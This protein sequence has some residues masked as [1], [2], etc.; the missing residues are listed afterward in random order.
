MAQHHANG[1]AGSPGW[2]DGDFPDAP[3]KPDPDSRSAATPDPAGPDGRA[4]PDLR[5]EGDRGACVQ[6][7]GNALQQN[8]L[9]QKTAQQKSLRQTT[10]QQTTPQQR[11]AQQKSLRQT[12]PQQTT[13]QQTTQPRKALSS[14]FGR[15]DWFA[16]PENFGRRPAAGTGRDRARSLGRSV[17]E[18][19]QSL[20]GWRGHGGWP[21]P[22]GHRQHEVG[23]PAV[24]RPADPGTQPRRWQLF[25]AAASLAL[26]SAAVGGI[27][28]GFVAAGNAGSQADPGYSVSL[29]PPAPPSRPAGSVAGVAARDLPGVVMIK[30]NGGQG[31]G[32]GFVIQGGYI[33]TDNHVVTLDGLA[34]NASIRVY[35]SDG[36]SAAAQ[37]VGRDPYSDIAV[38]KATGVTGLPALSLG[39][40]GTVAVGDPV[41]AIGSPLGLVDTV[42][43]GIVSAV[44]RP[45]QPASA[46]GAAPQDFFDAIQTDA[47]IN[48][49][50]SGGPLV[51]ARGQVIGVDAAIDTLGSD[52][53]TGTQGG[54]IGLGFAIPVNQARRII[55]EL[56]RTGHATHSVLGADLNENFAGAGAQVATSGRGVV[57]GGPAARAGLHPGDVITKLGSQPIMSADSLL[58]AI[59]SLPPGSTVGIT[60]SRHGQRMVARITLGSAGS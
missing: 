60:F 39:N 11:T 13:P 9:Q 22:P 3:A 49:G 42:T 54:S 32:S 29:G 16:E 18:T 25:G 4:R 1:S 37:V 26:V 12:T 41:L 33:V 28:G 56:I 48:P 36:R 58:D 7:Q 45:V 23:D 52:P 17:G 10:P 59:R 27:A 57:P 43:S 53:I 34:G 21:P 31:T 8:V 20:P 2:P 55:V 38:I 5:L 15:F 44:N 14:D 35:F 6:A 30:V 50:N 47:P 51:N 40:S 24:P 19:W 46:D